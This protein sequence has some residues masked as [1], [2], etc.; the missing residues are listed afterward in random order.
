MAR[1]TSTLITRSATADR[2]AD[3]EEL[4][5]DRG[6][7]GGCWCMAWRLSRSDYESGKGAKHKRRLKR[8]VS[9]AIPP[10]IL[11]Y[12]D[13][14]AVA[15]C[16]VAPRTEYDFLTRSRVLKPVDEKPVWSVSCLFVERSLRRQGVATAMLKAAVGFAAGHGARVV[17]GYPVEP[18]ENPI[19]AAFAWTGI[20][21][22][23]LKAGFHEVARR[24]PTRPIMRI[25]VRREDP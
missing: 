23:F 19:P 10:G 6:A 17:E 5:G 24:S 25:D 15:W 13:G 18:V 11:G 14:R 1:G 12:A 2:W 3:L 16:S 8:L 21:S 7:C 20:P 22:A 9:G 4:F